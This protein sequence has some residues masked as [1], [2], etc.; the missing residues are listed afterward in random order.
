MRIYEKAKKFFGALKNVY[1]KLTNYD[2]LEKQ[3]TT[4]VNKTLELSEQVGRFK[5]RTKN[6]FSTMTYLSKYLKNLE[7]FIEE[8]T[9][10]K[11]FL[12]N[13]LSITQKRLLEPLQEISESPEYRT[14]SEEK[15]V[16]TTRAEGLEAKVSELETLCR[17]R[18]KTIHKLQVRL[19]EYDQKKIGQI[20]NSYEQR[21]EKID[22]GQ[23]YIIIRESSRIVTS[24]PEF[25]KEFNYNNPD[26]PIKGLN[27]F[28][29]L[30]IP[31]DSPDYISQ[32]QMKEVLKDPKEVKLTTT[33]RD[34][35]GEEKIIRFIKHVPESFP[36]GEYNYFYTRVD[37][38]EIG[39]VERAI[40]GVLRTL[41]II[42]K[43]PKTIT[44]FLR[45]HAINDVK[46]E[47]DQEKDKILS[48]K[49]KESK[50]RSKWFRKRTN[51][52]DSPLKTI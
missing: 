21:A 2:N 6:L 51:K 39:R 10:Q 43:P 48:K 15:E 32:K 47:T 7:Y 23:S 11:H 5:Q 44:E 42:D 3:H 24:T 33:I 8:L 27:W 22:K 37:I 41:H 9:E 26:K 4:Q 14:V 36:I 38:Y 25:R 46:K 30:I 18:D 12:S 45:Q 40:G 13:E 35:K 31:E 29:V 49:P 17:F 20:E 52:P 1:F 19:R 34:G 28:K 50:P 16:L